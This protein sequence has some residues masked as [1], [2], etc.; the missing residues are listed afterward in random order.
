MYCWKAVAGVSA[1]G[2]YTGT[3]GAFTS[4]DIG[5]KPRWILFRGTG[6]TDW[7]LIDSFRETATEQITRFYVNSDAAEATDAALG[8][9]FTSTGWTFDSGTNSG[10]LNTTSD[11]YYYAAFA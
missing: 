11:V 10:R 6:P 8:T 1:F 4:P 2:T 9:T 3:G 5:F 7:I